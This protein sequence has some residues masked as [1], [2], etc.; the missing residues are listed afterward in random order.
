MINSLRVPNERLSRRSELLWTAAVHLFESGLIGHPSNAAIAKYDEQANAA[1]YVCLFHDWCPEWAHQ[2]FHDSQFADELRKFLARAR[3][4]E[5]KGNRVAATFAR[6]YLGKEELQCLELIGEQLKKISFYS[7]LTS[8]DLEAVKQ[9]GRCWTARDLDYD[10]LSTAEG[11]TEMEAKT[12]KDGH[13]QYGIELEKLYLSAK[14]GSIFGQYFF[15]DRSTAEVLCVT[16]ICRSEKD[17]HKLAELATVLGQF[18]RDFNLLP[19]A[20]RR[21]SPRVRQKGTS[22]PPKVASAP[23]LIERMHFGFNDKDAR[24]RQSAAERIGKLSDKQLAVL[25]SLT[26]I[27]RGEKHIPLTQ[28][29]EALERV[30]KE[31]SFT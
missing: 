25:D 19:E 24:R 11:R 4:L 30:E 2:K 28:M 15:R 20:L 21:D 6:E 10:S 26:V 3:D 18:K 1:S 5:L 16:A 12:E 8:L 27:P 29:E 7:P 31:G 9:S 23:D 22:R 13:W 17:K 14:T